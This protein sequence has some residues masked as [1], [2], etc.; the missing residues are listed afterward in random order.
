[1]TQCYVLMCSYF[2]QVGN[3]QME[4]GYSFAL[5]WF[6]FILTLVTGIVSLVASVP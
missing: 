1:M 2:L 3:M 5:A 4:Y 6:S